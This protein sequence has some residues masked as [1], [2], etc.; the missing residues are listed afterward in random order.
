M[1]G[2]LQSFERKFDVFAERQHQHGDVK[3]CILERCF[4]KREE[5][6]IEDS[7]Y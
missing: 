3:I 6:A 1:S 7:G 4:S 2:I 5:G